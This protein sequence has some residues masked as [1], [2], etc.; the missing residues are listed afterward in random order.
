MYFYCNPMSTLRRKC[1]TTHLLLHIPASLPTSPPPCFFLTTPFAR[2][3]VL[4]PPL[5]FLTHELGPSLPSIVRTCDPGPALITQTVQV[6]NKEPI[7][8]AGSKGKGT[9]L[10]GKDARHDYAQTRFHA[11]QVLRHAAPSSCG[12]PYT[13]S[14]V[15]GSS[16]AQTA[17]SSGG[18]CGRGGGGWEEAS[19]YDATG[20]RA[21]PSAADAAAAAAAML[22]SRN[23]RRQ[24][25]RQEQEALRVILHGGAHA[26]VRARVDS[27]GALR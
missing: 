16:T 20:E 2:S 18:G 17:A 27:I 10:G 26:C 15:A 3:P 19:L 22:E 25:E 24:R 13:R 9:M 4:L 8:P 6:S 5:T 1:R 21:M 11:V 23:V 14:S 12:T 7:R